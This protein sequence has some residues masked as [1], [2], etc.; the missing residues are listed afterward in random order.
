[1][2]MLY[3]CNITSCESCTWT[4]YSC[5]ITSCECCTSA[6]LHHVK[7]VHVHLQYYIMW[8]LFMYIC[9]ITSCENC[10]CT[11]A[12]LHH[13]KT[14]HVHL[15]YYIMWK[16][17][18]W[19]ITLC[20]CVTSAPLVAYL[21]TKCMFIIGRMRMHLVANGEWWGYGGMSCSLFFSFLF[22]NF[23]LFFFSAFFCL[24]MFLLFL[25]LCAFSYTENNTCSGDCDCA[26]VVV[27][28]SC[29]I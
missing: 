18:I 25:L 1:M 11:S 14:V 20:A 2:W 15:Q 16:L 28:L 6:V 26:D 10:S 8:K 29:I 22:L 7:T 17:F 19:N 12:V 9:S 23:F 21:S 3:I 24:L 27:L 5:S 13:V 4:L